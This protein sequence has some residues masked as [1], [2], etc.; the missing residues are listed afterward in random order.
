MDTL[1][2]SMA[3]EILKKKYLDLR[4]AGNSK[5]LSLAK[6]EVG[7]THLA[8]KE[9]LEGEKYLERVDERYGNVNIGAVPKY[10]Y[11]FMKP[12]SKQLLSPCK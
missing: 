8:L 1:D 10:P 6:I 11:N 12:F 5:A 4:D 3:N 7:I 2:Q 9:P